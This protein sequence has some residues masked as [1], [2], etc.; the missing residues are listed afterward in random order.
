MHINAVAAAVLAALVLAVD[1]FA[2]PLRVAVF[3]DK[4]ARNTGAFRWVEIVS[5]MKDAEFL[6]VTGK[7][8]REGA[9]DRADVLVVPG[10][11]SVQEAKMLGE[12]G[13]EKVR[14]FLK[15]GGG[16]IGTCAGC[17]LLMEPSKC[18]PGMLGA[19]PFK[20]SKD[21]GGHA[22]LLVGFNSRAEALAGIKKGKR[23]VRYS[24]GPILLPSLPVDEAEIEI[25]G[26][27][28]SDVNQESKPRVSFA[29]HPAAVAGTYGKGRI[30]AFSVHPEY[31][32]DDHDLIKGAFRYVTG[33]ETEWDYPQRKPGMN[34]IGVV[35]DDSMGTET[36]KT[37][38]DVLREGRYDLVPINAGDVAS[39]ILRRLDTIV[40]P[41]G[42]GS[43]SPDSGLWGANTAKTKEFM[44]RGGK[45]FSWGAAAKH[46]AKQD[47]RAVECAD[48]RAAF[49]AAAACKT[50]WTK[51][52][53]APLPAGAAKKV[54]I[55]CD[56][57]GANYSVL[58]ML[59]LSPRFDVEI[60]DAADVR[61]GALDGCD[62]LL[63][64][65]GSCRAQHLALGPDGEAAI[66]RYVRSGGSY[67]GICAGAFL[68]TQTNKPDPEYARMGLVPF[69]DDK[70][71]HYRGW[72][73][74]AVSLTAA[75]RKFFRSSPAER[76]V[77]YWGGPVLVPG[78]PV[79]DARID[80]LATYGGQL[81][82]TSSSKPVKPMFGK[83]AFL[84][85]TVGAGRIFISC[86]HPEKSEKDFDIV[87][88]AI[89]FLTGEAPETAGKDKRPGA[90]PVFYL[91]S[92]NKE[93]ARQFASKL[94]AD[95]SIDL[96]VG[97]EI[98]MNALPHV[99]AVYV[100]DRN[101]VTAA[102]KK[103]LEWFRSRGGE[104]VEL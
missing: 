48:D 14:S 84:A 26:Y 31:D 46:A 18:H 66:A 39:G 29:G 89:R 90:K 41:D 69:K 104:V 10:G 91:T 15:A 54:A 83:A 79:P 25:V 28:A 77:M 103:K 74:A 96:R 35:A 49:A 19:I 12:A 92:R 59:A 70:P 13:R 94:L 38:G 53:A 47:G 99:E 52:A 36:A 43:A 51:P 9:L 72:G 95:D 86:P 5:R 1:A 102:D 40:A 65:G 16:Y 21:I 63:Q 3:V 64:P 75:G 98:D 22:D 20:F 34:A 2:A 37:I 81:L 50:R 85:G 23:R 42:A 71:E 8:I 88:D 76:E 27:Y 24:G 73:P 44:D 87:A 57:G 45:V 55:Y 30:F 7:T 11:K 97:S 100:A 6:P 78:D 93:K 67:Y 68:A 56:K 4:G 33:R 82:N 80:V 61:S 101:D 62:M 17:C 32:V 58:T 60:V